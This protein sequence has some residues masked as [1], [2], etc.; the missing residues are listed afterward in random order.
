MSSFINTNR[1]RKKM[2]EKTFSTEC[3]SEALIKKEITHLM[4]IGVLK[5]HCGTIGWATKTFI[6]PKKDGRVC[7]IQDFKPSKATQK[8]EWN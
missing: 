6:V 2:H 5:H 8:R 3:T 4:G 7:W 1:L